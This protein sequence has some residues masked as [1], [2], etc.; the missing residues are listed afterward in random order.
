MDAALSTFYFVRHAKAG[1]RGHWQGD[2]RLRPVSKKGVKQAEELID[3]FKPFNISA[4]YSSPYLR[5]VQTV[6]PLAHDRELEIQETPALAEGRGLPGAFEFMGD[7]ELDDVVLSTHGDIVWELVED[8]VRRRVIRAGEGGYE[9]G[10]TW[11]VEVDKGKP[12][13]ARFI[14]AP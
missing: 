6:E 12:V 14:P 8:L 7:P 2:D 13:R 3:L 5:C 9:K 11:V 10:S 1:S 4:I